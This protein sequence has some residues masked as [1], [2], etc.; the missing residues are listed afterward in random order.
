V[1]ECRVSAAAHPTFGS[2]PVAEI[3]PTGGGA[4]PP[5]PSELMG[6]CR[7]RLS[8]YKLPVKFSYVAAIP[9]TASGKIQR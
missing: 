6:W 1:A 7:A 9:K 8:S 5:K 4:E 2:V 3:V